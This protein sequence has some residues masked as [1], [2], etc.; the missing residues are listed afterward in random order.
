MIIVNI[1][2]WFG[3]ESKLS[4]PNHLLIFIKTYGF[5]LPQS[6]SY[7]CGLLSGGEGVDKGLSYKFLV[8]YSY[9]KRL[10]VSNFELSIFVLNWSILTRWF[11][12]N[13]GTKRSKFIE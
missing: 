13:G 3:S 9:P 2:R 6:P 7:S 11:S 1:K 8:L 10:P 5:K 12:E 4:T